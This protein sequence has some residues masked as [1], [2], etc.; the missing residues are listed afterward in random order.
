MLAARTGN[1]LVMQYNGSWDSVSS[2]GCSCSEGLP[3]LSEQTV[4]RP[5]SDEWRGA[6]GVQSD[7]SVQY[8]QYTCCKRTCAYFRDSDQ[9]GSPTRYPSDPNCCGDACT[10]T[11]YYDSSGGQQDKERDC[12]L[13]PFL[14]FLL[15]GVCAT[16]GSIAGFV[17]QGKENSEFEARGETVEGRVVAK[18]ISIVVRSSK[19]RRRREEHYHM[20]YSFCIRGANGATGPWQKVTKQQEISGGDYSRITE[21]GKVNIVHI[22]AVTNNPKNAIPE[23]NLQHEGARACQCVF[24]TIVGCIFML[25][26]SLAFLG[27]CG[28]ATVTLV[29][30]SSMGCCFGVRF[31]S[32]SR[33]NKRRDSPDGDL[34]QI[35]AEQAAAFNTGQAMQPEAWGNPQA[36]FTPGMGGGSMW[37]GV[38]PTDCGTMMHVTCPEGA[39][40]GTFLCITTPSG[41]QMQVAVPLNV[42]PGEMF[43]VVI[44][45]A[46]PAPPPIATAVAVNPVACAPPPGELK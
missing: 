14:I 2:E 33:V 20:T 45:A 18:N 26:G 15:V 35:S 22:A 8:W 27:G 37:T 1:A 21:G 40:T 10:P 9:F 23:F 30:C 44:P 34:D 28:S 13:F 25:F 31:M 38:Q 3:K 6:E 39:T 4:S 19:G 32:L 5:M 36:Q 46:A 17:D 42:S 29:V 12:L 43:Q 11:P 7:G 16:V 41:Q 24:S